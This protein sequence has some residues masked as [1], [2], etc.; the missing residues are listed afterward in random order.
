MRRRQPPLRTSRS[1]HL[2]ARALVAAALL[3]PLTATVPSPASAATPASATAAPGD[4]T[5]SATAGASCWGI[6]RAF[7]ASPSGSYWVLT[8]AMDRPLEVYCDQVTDGGGWTLIG[9]GREN[10]SFADAG[11]GTAAAVRT[12]IDGP[13]AFAAA[14]LPAAT[15]DALANGA[16]IARLSDGIRVQ[17]SLTA[18]GSSRQEVRLY[19]AYHRWTWAMPTGQKLTRQVIAGTTYANGNTRDSY[20]PYYDYPASTLAGKQGTSRLMTWAWIKNDYKSGFG[21]GSGVTG[22][23]SAT[24]HLYQTATGYAIPFTRVWLRPRLANDGVT[25]TSIPAAGL[26]ADPNQPSLKTRTEVA[27]WGVVGL[28]HTGEATV[29]PWQNPATVI[30]AYGSRIYVGGRFTHVQQ[31]PTGTKVA[32]GSLAAFDLDGNWISTFRPT[33]N[34]RVWDMTTTTDGTLIIG[35]DFTSVNGAA[36]TSGLA[37]LDPITGALV[38]GWRV[39]VTNTTGPMIVR[40]LDRRGSTI[41]AAGRFDRVQGGSAPE[42][43][44]ASAISLGATTGAP[45]TWRPRLTGSAIKVRAAAA[46]DRVYL[47]GFFTAVNGNAAHA[48]HAITSATSGTPVTGVGAY[49]PSTSGA[50]YQQAVAESSDGQQ[51]LVG[52]S[53]HTFQFYDRS[54]TTLLDA[55][56]T[57]AGGDT[58]A[59]EVFGNDVY[60]ACHCDQAIMQ[61]TNSYAHPAGFR[62]IS[63]IMLIGRFDAT[64]HEYDRTW[65]PSA[66]KGEA[67]EGIWG[68]TRDSRSCLWVAGDLT[69][70]AATGDAASDWLGGFGR[71]CAADATPPSTPTGLTATVGI[72]AVSLTWGAS[73]DAGGTPTY[74]VLRDDRVIATVTG[75]SY[76][77][78]VGTGTYRYTVRAADPSGNRSAAPAPLTRSVVAVTTST[79]LAPGSTWRWRFTTASTPSTWKGDAFDATSWASATA[80]FGYGDP[81]TTT[82]AAPGNEKPLTAY[83]RTTIT[84]ADPTSIDEVLLDLVRNSGAAVYVNGVE[85]ARSNLPAG[86]LTADTYASSYLAADERT[87]PVR[88]TI[89]ASR[90]R[91]GTNTVAVELHLN[92]RS[93]PTAGF[94]LGLTAVS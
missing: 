72:N 73:T 12:A 85:V 60:M 8:P 53:Q 16:D 54:R 77:D 90:L 79:L 94:D 42:I 59:I 34:G 65:Y 25:F 66:L 11:Q 26:P 43:T 74:D 44:V 4:G 83:F 82:L 15:V 92:S 55:N 45:G 41:Y 3:A 28:N 31:G 87:T 57:K 47:A 68:I 39:K 29:S 1:R 64:T 76:V 5:T 27:P 69:R 70:G 23:T 62:S 49:Q 6:K 78:P 80:S 33:V 63:P 2:A 36:N 18:T 84:V 32:Q 13:S 86:T 88:F 21:Y 89:P 56:I 14:T 40:A 9:R 10:W 17:R 7:P 51:L 48:Y 91:A 38:S 52:G 19:A 61:G 93:Q 50:R 30:K 24:T 67:T 22:S 71:F 20:S 75:T 46:G 35:G 81:H 37:A 58:Q